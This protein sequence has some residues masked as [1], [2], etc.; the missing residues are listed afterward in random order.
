VCV[1]QVGYGVDSDC[2]AIASMRLNTA[3]GVDVPFNPKGFGPTDTRHSTVGL[4]GANRFLCIG[5]VIANQG[6]AEGCQVHSEIAG[7]WA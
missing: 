2:S 4:L 1:L 3:D 6:Y 5:I 7:S